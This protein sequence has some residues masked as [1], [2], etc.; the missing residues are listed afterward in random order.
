MESVKEHCH[1]NID[2]I[3]RLKLSHVWDTV[4][5]LVKPDLVHMKQNYGTATNVFTVVY[6]KNTNRTYA[7]VD[8]SAD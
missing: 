5:N 8:G 6:Y 3:T 2:D 4:A 1:I 7:I